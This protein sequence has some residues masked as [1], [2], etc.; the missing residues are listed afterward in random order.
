[1]P[2]SLALRELRGAVRRSKQ[3]G[4]RAVSYGFYFRSAYK[5]EHLLRLVRLARHYTL[6][7]FRAQW[8]CGYFLQLQCQ[9][10]VPLIPFFNYARAG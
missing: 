7:G 6:A 5:F 2:P 8:K 1:M 3:I 10:S 4:A 9:R